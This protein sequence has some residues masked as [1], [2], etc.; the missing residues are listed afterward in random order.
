MWPQTPEQRLHSWYQLRLDTADMP[1]E[2]C[3]AAVNDWWFLAPMNSRYL[4][5]DDV[6]NWPTPWELLN[7]NI[8]CDVARA[9][10]MLYTIAIIERPEITELS[11][12][13]TDEDNLV[14]I[15]QGKYILN[16][17]NQQVVN[18]N[19]VTSTEI[20]KHISSENFQHVIR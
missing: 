4:H 16:W 18:I 17:G 12:F 19:S 20:K 9:L 11:M 10:G 1:L 8:F 5:W 6:D 13:Q 2:S 7:D 15:N 3:L 14:Q